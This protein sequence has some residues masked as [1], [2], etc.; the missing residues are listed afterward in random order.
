MLSAIFLHKI[1]FV[2]LK[3]F[4]VTWPS[5]SRAATGCQTDHRR[6]P[7]ICL[8][9]MVRF[10]TA[11]QRNRLERLLLRLRRDGFLPENSSSFEE[12]ARDADLGLF[13]SISSNPF[14]VLR[15]Y[16]PEREHTGYNLR[17]RA[18]NFH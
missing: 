13:R 12:L 14:H 17:P 9:G 2:C 7:G 10:T 6:L 16:F 15:H 18:H 11:E 8:A 5:S 4:L 1:I 3:N